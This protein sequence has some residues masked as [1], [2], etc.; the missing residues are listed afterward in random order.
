MNNYFFTI[1]RDLLS[2]VPKHLRDK[3]NINELEQKVRVEHFE[4]KGMTNNESKLMLL[5]KVNHHT[6]YGSI[7]FTVLVNF[8]LNNLYSHFSVKRKE[9]LV[10]LN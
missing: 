1:I 5:R 3:I 6:L 7:I 4:L 10:S 2:F 9:E 8:Q